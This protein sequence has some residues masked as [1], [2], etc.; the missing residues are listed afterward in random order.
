MY[1][2]K[3][4]TCLFG[5]QKS[6]QRRFG[7]D[8]VTLY[9]ITRGIGGVL[10]TTLCVKFVSDFSSTVFFCKYSGFS[11]IS[12]ISWQSVLLEKTAVSGEYHLPVTSH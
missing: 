5:T 6:V 4:N 10:D 12:L 2:Y 1:L 11:N 8:S 9:M 3:P 7:I